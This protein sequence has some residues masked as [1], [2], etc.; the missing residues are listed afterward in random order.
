MGQNPRGCHE[1]FRCVWP[2]I[3]PATVLHLL[4][5]L[6][7]LCLILLQP[8]PSSLIIVGNV[9]SSFTTPFANC[10]IEPRILSSWWFTERSWR[11]STG[12][13]SSPR[14]RVLTSCPND[15][16]LVIQESSLALGFG[17]VY[18][19][20]I[21]PLEDNGKV[22]VIAPYLV[23]YQEALSMMMTVYLQAFRFSQPLRCFDDGRKTVG[24]HNTINPEGAWPP[25][26]DRISLGAQFDGNENDSGVAR[27]LSSVG[28]EADIEA[29]IV[30]ST[31]YEDLI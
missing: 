4:G 28:S 22:I 30:S 8:Q 10:S 26:Q 13:N 23:E 7:S 2:W 16:Q 12:G 31:Q 17:K 19:L 11:D 14:T 18:R 15:F 27:L 5:Y 21:A 25:A 3:T 1:E 20:V 6:S 24:S 29:D 9:S